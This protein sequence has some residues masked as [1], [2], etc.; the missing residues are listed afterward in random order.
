MANIQAKIDVGAGEYEVA[1]IEIKMS[2][3][4]FMGCL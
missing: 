3:L 4:G 1:G 2:E